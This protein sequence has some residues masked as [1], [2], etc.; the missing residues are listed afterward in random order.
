MARNAQNSGRSEKAAYTVQV[1]SQGTSVRLDRVITASLGALTADDVILDLQM[2]KIQTDGAVRERVATGL[3]HWRKDP[4]STQPI[5]AMEGI[6]PIHGRDTELAWSPECD[7][8]CQPD[9]V[10][11]DDFSHYASRLITLKAG[12]RIGTVTPAG[13][14]QPGMNIY[15]NEV[16]ARPG[17]P[18]GLRLDGCHV[19]AGND[20]VAD[21]DGILRV[22]PNAIVI[23]QELVIDGSVDFKTGHIDAPRDVTITGHVL[24]LFRVTAG[25]NITIRGSVQSAEIR[26]SGNVAIGAG[27]TNHRKGICLAGGDMALRLANNSVAAARGNIVIA[28]ESNS[29]DLFAMGRI[30]C[31]KGSIT[32]G[33]TLARGGV[34]AKEIGSSAGARTVVIAGVDW[35]LQSQLDP[36]VKELADLE[37]KLQPVREPLQ[38]LMANLKR[39]T[40]AQREQVTE[41]EFELSEGEERRE[42]LQKRMEQLRQESL[43]ACQPS[44]TVLGEVHAEVELRLGTLRTTLDQPFRG[45]VKFV[46]EH[47]HDDWAIVAKLDRTGH[48]MPLHNDSLPGVLQGITLPEAPPEP[49]P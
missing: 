31:M 4:L 49:R 44:I 40:H 12:Q 6:A 10:E 26:A 17:K 43:Q 37:K 20:L 48:T 18:L 23:S 29:S 30:E 46:L 3:D 9:R 33:I 25:G 7:P 16:P 38:V 27:L 34:T 22:R 24:D 11:S 39:L 21:D 14:G 1:E 41:L 47:I 45:P 5:V 13:A 35:L 28:K 32:G 36:M 19:D 8:V 15:G 42:L 2:R